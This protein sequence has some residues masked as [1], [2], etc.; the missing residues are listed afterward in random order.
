MKDIIKPA[1]AL[2]FISVIAAGLLGAVNFI[3]KDIISENNIKE[4][5]IA[6]SEVLPNVID[7]NFSDDILVE[8]KPDTG[9]ISYNTGFS[10]NDIVGY[11]MTVKQP[12]YSGI[13]Q[14]LVGMDTNGTVTGIK[15]IEHGETPGLGANATSSKFRSQFIGKSGEISVTKNQNPA[16]NEIVAITAA[17]I[18][19]RAVANGVNTALEFYDKNLKKGGDQ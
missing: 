5:N 16:D 3:T 19:S 4:K 13:M 18:T 8:P 17:T 12:G 1:I 6:M 11:V 10:G 2:F 15:L 14:L 7:N 9:V